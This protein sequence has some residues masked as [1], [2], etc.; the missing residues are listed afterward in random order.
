MRNLAIGS[1]HIAHSSVD[2]AEIT[3]DALQTYPS[4]FGSARGGV[5]S[6]GGSGDGVCGGGG[7]GVRGGS[8]SGSGSGSSGIVI[9]AVGQEGGE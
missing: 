1:G 5:L 6:C 7:L 3:L 9:A 4:S 2:A 8:G